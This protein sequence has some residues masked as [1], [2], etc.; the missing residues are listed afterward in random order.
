MNRLESDTIPNPLAA[1]SQLVSELSD[2]CLFFFLK[3]QNSSILC[4]SVFENDSFERS[5][6]F[7]RMSQPE[8]SY[9]EILL[10]LYRQKSSK[11]PQSSL[12]SSLR[13]F[14]HSARLHQSLILFLLLHEK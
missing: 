14:L 12:K 7:F 4:F 8:K 9:L 5:G 10:S 6:I 1:R 3:T 11:L 13:Q 2:T